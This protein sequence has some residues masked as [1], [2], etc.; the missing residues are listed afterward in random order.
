M[1]KLQ[2]DPARLLQHIVVEE[3]NPVET[4]FPLEPVLLW[5]AC[6]KLAP[7][8]AQDSSLLAR[9]QRRLEVAEERE[10]LIR[11]EEGVKN[12]ELLSLWQRLQDG[13][14]S[15]RHLVAAGFS[16]TPTSSHR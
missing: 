10:V 12:L 2:Q 14:G 6:T 8:V 13:E 9:I 1:G 7:G 15:I 4:S 16:K 11:G 5:L 3:V